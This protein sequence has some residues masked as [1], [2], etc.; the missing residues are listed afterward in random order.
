[1]LPTISQRAQV[2]DS[3]NTLLPKFLATAVLSLKS[4]TDSLT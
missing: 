3:H 2:D 1:M 4:P